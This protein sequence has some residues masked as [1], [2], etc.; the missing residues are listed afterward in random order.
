MCVP[1]IADAVSDVAAYRSNLDWTRSYVETFLAERL[2]GAKIEL[3][4]NTK[5]DF[6]IP[7]L[8]LTAIGSS[9]ESGDEGLVGRGNRPNGLIA[10]RRPYSMEGLCGKNPVYHV[11][12]LYSLVA[13]EASRALHETFGVPAEVW[14]VSQEGRQLNDPWQAVVRSSADLPE[15]EA[16]AVLQKCLDGIP[17]ITDRL[18]AGQIEPY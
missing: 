3:W 9:I 5:D 1:Q 15:A 8:Y 13:E 2:P 18:L 10:M 4:F 17:S 6:D 14:L 7:E 11:G 12:K 16:R